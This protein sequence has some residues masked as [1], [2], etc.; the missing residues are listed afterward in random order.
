M[1]DEKRVI[2]I[3]VPMNIIEGLIQHQIKFAEYIKSD[4]PVIIS[5]G[6]AN[7]SMDDVNNYADD[8][9]KLCANGLAL[10]Y[11]LDHPKNTLKGQPWLKEGAISLLNKFLEN[12]EILPD[13]TSKLK[14]VGSEWYA[15]T[16]TQVIKTLENEVD[17]LTKTKAKAYVEAYAHH[18]MEEPM[19][20]TAFNHESWRCWTLYNAGL[21]FDKPEWCERS[22]FFL[23][24]LLHCQTKEGFW[25]ESA[26]HGPSMKYNQLM[27]S[28]LAWISRLSNDA[29][30]KDAAIRLGSFMS[31]W[32]FPDGTTVGTFDGRQSTS[33]MLFSP[34][35]PGLEFTQAGATLNQRGI[36]LWA[37]RGCLSEDRALGNSNWYGHFSSFSIADSLW[38]FLKYSPT[39]KIGVLEIDEPKVS[40]E[41]H[42]VHFDGILKRWN[43]WCLAVSGQNSDVPRMV[44]NVFRLDRQSRLELW[45]QD[46]GVIL[47]GGHNITTWDIP[48]AN[49]I[50]DSNGEV[51][52]E[53]GYIE[54]SKKRSG[55]V[56]KAM[57]IPR[58]VRSF[59]ESNATNLELIFGHGTFLFKCSPEN[60]NEF[61]LTLHWNVRGIKK[62]YLQLPMLLWRLGQMTIDGQEINGREPFLTNSI[63]SATFRDN[64]KQTITTIV[65]PK[66][67]VTKI[68]TGLSQ[69][70]SY[71]KLFENE[72][73]DPPYFINQIS[74]EV[75]NP[76][77][78]GSLNWRITVQKI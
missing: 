41:N 65:P 48:Y 49:V 11:T 57:F 10:L 64:I 46:A 1:L 27:L 14:E 23:H 8:N 44:A 71:G 45:H 78:I 47:G 15:Y 31:R 30:I 70:R 75:L 33:L 3:E 73:F 29:K 51:A 69:I 52:N 74:T 55:R 28:P 16:V 63:Q 58:M 39:E 20:F 56:S 38:Y 24:Q 12:V 43:N 5:S 22:L 50:I 17:D 36:Q 67:L 60:D 25:E 42:S 34:V 76:S 37:A 62:M 7:G 35:V 18:A 59:S 4:L 9:Y 26:H 40:L 21:Y 2:F 32:V 53:F 6:G 19:F 77:N 66:G 72:R 54:P 61:S 13:G 68:R